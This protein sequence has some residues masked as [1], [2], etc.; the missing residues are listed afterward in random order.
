M[1]LGVFPSL[2]HPPLE[3]MG[4]ATSALLVRFFV[5][6]AED[7]GN[8]NIALQKNK[9]QTKVSLSLGAGSCLHHTIYIYRAV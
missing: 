9:K 2:I 8:I 1:V 5:P 6:E 7:L 3:A 4:E